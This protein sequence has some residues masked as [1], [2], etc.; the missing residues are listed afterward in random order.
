[1]GGSDLQ[2]N[3]RQD[4]YLEVIYVAEKYCTCAR[5]RVGYFW[6]QSRQIKISV[7]TMCCEVISSG[8]RF[9]EFAHLGSSKCR[10]PAY[11]ISAK[12]FNPRPRYYYFRFLKTN[13]RHRILLPV[14]IYLFASHR[15]VILHLSTKFR[16]NRSICDRVMT[17]YSFSRWRPSAILNYFKVTADHLRSANGGPRLVLKFRLDRFYSFGDIAI[18]VL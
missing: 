6:P 9:A 3:C 15:H 18:F 5:R 17:S 1:M 8:F 16:L 7:S 14:P 2:S 4:V 13:G 11:Q 10:L 12:Y